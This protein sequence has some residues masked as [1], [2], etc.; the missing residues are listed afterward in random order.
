MQYLTKNGRVVKALDLH[1][2]GSI[3]DCATDSLYV[4]RQVSLSLPQFTMSKMI[5]YDNNPYLT[6]VPFEDTFIYGCEVHR[7]CGDG[8]STVNIIIIPHRKSPIK[9]A[10]MQQNKYI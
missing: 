3:P 8:S 4:L 9:V 7:H 6:G 2:L 10:I 1:H 5:W